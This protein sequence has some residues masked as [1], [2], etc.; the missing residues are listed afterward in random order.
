MSRSLVSMVDGHLVFGDAVARVAD[1][2]SPL[3]AA[4]RIVA[5]SYACLTAM[6][7][8]NLA[9]RQARDDHEARMA[10]LQNRRVEA[11]ASL[12]Q[13]RNRVGQAA[14]A[15]VRHRVRA[16]GRTAELGLDGG[17]V[18]G[19]DRAGH[20]RLPPRKVSGLSFWSADGGSPASSTDRHSVV[21]QAVGV[22]VLAVRGSLSVSL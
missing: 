22:E 20:R 7:E 14:R 18:A 3:G 9:G 15:P 1:S 8:L 13:M 4:A 11:S 10:V 12:R 5:E 2:R 21:H 16:T 17:Q 19:R 6:R